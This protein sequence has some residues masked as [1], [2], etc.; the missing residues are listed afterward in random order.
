MNHFSSQWGNG[1]FPIGIPRC[2]SQGHFRVPRFLMVSLFFRK[3]CVQAIVYTKIYLYGLLVLK[4]ICTDSLRIHLPEIESTTISDFQDTYSTNGQ[5]THLVDIS[6]NWGSFVILKEFHLQRCLS[7]SFSFFLRMN[8]TEISYR[9]LCSIFKTCQ[10]QKTQSPRRVSWVKDR[11]R[12][13]NP[14]FCPPTLSEFHCFDYFP[15]THSNKPRSVVFLERFRTKYSFNLL[16]T[17]VFPFLRNPLKGTQKLF[18]TLSFP[19]FEFE[20]LYHSHRN[21][22]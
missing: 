5:K 9:S 22:R 11:Q 1:D 6:E 21:S 7:E 12:E 20:F 13:R 8:V 4:N 3:P 2:V 15:S 10:I 19:L 17:H 14:R 16:C 18:W